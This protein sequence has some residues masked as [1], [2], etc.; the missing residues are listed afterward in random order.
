MNARIVAAVVRLE[1]TRSRRVL[2][3]GSG[4][5]IVG[6]V[7][8]FAL[9]GTAAAVFGFVAGCTVFATVMFAPLSTLLAEKLLGTLELDRTLPVSTRL[10]ATAR[11]VA[12][13][14]RTLPMLLLL[15]IVALFV[16]RALPPVG[17]LTLAF[18]VGAAQVLYWS[19]LWIGY[20]LLAR[21]DFKKLIWLPA[22]LWF[23]AVLAPDAVADAL[24]R[25]VGEP[26][27]TMLAAAL[28]DPARLPVLGVALLALA[29]LCF[30]IALL[31]VTSGLR[32]FQ[33]DP[34][35]LQGVV[36]EVPREELTPARRGA[37]VAV[38]RLR[39]RLVTPQVRR[40][41]TIVA[42]ML[43]LLTLEA[44]GVSQLSVLTGIARAYVPVLAFMMP[45]AIGLQL[46]PA[47]QLGTIEGLQQ[48]PY[49]RRD[50]ALGHL[51]AVLLLSVPAVAI[52][53]VAQAIGG[54]LPGAD[55]LLRVWTA[56]GAGS[57]C[58]AGVVLWATRRRLLL[59]F[60]IPTALFLAGRTLLPA[61]GLDV[62][63]PLAAIFE[64]W[65][66]HRAWLAPATTL[67][68]FAVALALGMAMFA[69]GLRTYQ[70][71]AR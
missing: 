71:K 32:R 61:L 62:A 45:A 8:A 68:A 21:F 42:A 18:A 56:I 50:V 41:L 33:P 48:L 6:T 20:G 1:L 52:W 17:G 16:V 53:T 15:A 63:P 29:A 43:A 39:L 60:G 40:E 35:A 31:L 13:A 55:R 59:A 64:Y 9:D 23:T 2:V 67:S 7:G 22:L 3:W 49:P 65:A 37:V 54:G 46:L 19:V 51:L 36:E 28:T 26:A 4:L 58:M 38:M 66:A 5:A 11:L 25:A 30:G 27:T 34:L 14:V 10:L 44:F 69:H 12:A 24:W 70:P 57:W 47:R